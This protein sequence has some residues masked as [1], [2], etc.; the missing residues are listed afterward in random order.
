VTAVLG[1]EFRTRSTWIRCLATATITGQIIWLATIGL[2]GAIEPEYDPA[3]DAV[4]FLGARDSAHPWIFW[5]AVT[6]SGAS[7][8]AL[9]T[10]L[11]LDN[12]AGWQ[13][14]TGPILIAF[15]GGVQV[16]NGFIWPVDCRGTIDATC[17][18]RE[19][20][21]DVSWQH[22][23][24]KHAFFVGSAALLV[25]VFAMAWR[26]HGDPKWRQA[27]LGTLAAGLLSVALLMIAFHFFRE[28]PHNRFGVVQRIGLAGGGTWIIGLSLALLHLS[29]SVA[30][31]ATRSPRPERHDSSTQ[32]T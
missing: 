20:R 3:R 15:V 23:A 18:A 29:P 24:H 6:L 26:F 31:E 5:T 30:P 9:A 32:R 8:L 27:W 12:R 14:V 4:G 25:S 19:L 2:A 7:C 22:V 10:A 17:E 1:A 13:A 28:D 21:G 11:L 16:M